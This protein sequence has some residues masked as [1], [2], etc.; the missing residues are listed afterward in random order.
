M[1]ARRFTHLPARLLISVSVFLSSSCLLLDNPLSDPEKA[2]PDTQLFGVWQIS[3]AKGEKPKKPEFGLLLIG[4]SGVGGAPPGIM[5]II[6]CAIDKENKIDTENWFFFLTRNGSSSYMNLVFFEG[7][8]REGVIPASWDK[9]KVEGYGLLKIKS[10]EDKL[11]LWLGDLKAANAAIRKGQLKGKAE[12]GW[13]KISIIAGGETL[14]RFLE[15]GGDK[16]LFPDT[17]KN[18]VVFTRL[19]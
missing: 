9:V 3:E 4:K 19:K 6:Q 7:V 14:S 1:P 18:K 12:V 16:A 2:K 15:D 8:G 10:E 5:K 11:V 17:D 13:L